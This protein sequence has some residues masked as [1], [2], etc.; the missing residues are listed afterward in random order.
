MRL[1]C[2]TT[3]HGWIFTWLKQLVPGD[4]DSWL[5]QEKG[6]YPDFTNQQ[7]INGFI[8]LIERYAIGFFF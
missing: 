1:F 3:A 8:K 6:G 5:S 4:M 2:G 7:P